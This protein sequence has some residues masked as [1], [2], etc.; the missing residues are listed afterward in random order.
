MEEAMADSSV[1]SPITTIVTFGF[2]GLI[3]GGIVLYLGL[4]SRKKK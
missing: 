1:I 2:A 3:V 4:I